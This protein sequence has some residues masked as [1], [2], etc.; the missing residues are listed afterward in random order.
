MHPAVLAN[1]KVQRQTVTSNFKCHSNTNIKVFTIMGAW[2]CFHEL[3]WHVY[4]G[5]RKNSLPHRKCI[6]KA[7]ATRLTKMS[8]N[9][10]KS[11]AKFQ[12]YAVT[13]NFK[14][15]SITNLKVLTIFYGCSVRTVFPAIVAQTMTRQFKATQ[16][17]LHK[18]CATSIEKGDYQT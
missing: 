8:S 12:H 3:R 7:L 1:S 15:H 16:S 4:Y 5:N 6:V 9:A 18:P 14:G 17:R 13:S 11:L 10:Q 2:S